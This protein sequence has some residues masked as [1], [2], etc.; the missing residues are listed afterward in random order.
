MGRYFFTTNS[1]LGYRV[2][3][4]HFQHQMSELLTSVE[5]VQCQMNNTFV[6]RKDEAEHC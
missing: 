3:L 4:K 5:G 2:T 6:F 1:R